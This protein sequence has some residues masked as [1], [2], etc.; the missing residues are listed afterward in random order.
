MNKPHDMS[1]LHRR[2]AFAHRNSPF[3]AGF[4]PS[5]DD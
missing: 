2:A 4:S 1:N 5:R 3:S